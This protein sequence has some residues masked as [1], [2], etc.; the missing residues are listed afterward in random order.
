[1][2]TLPGLGVAGEKFGCVTFLMRVA[3][4][5][6]KHARAFV[7][8]FRRRENAFAHRSLRRLV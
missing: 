6:Q 3:S 2:G 4:G 8:E 7:F 5:A 1:M